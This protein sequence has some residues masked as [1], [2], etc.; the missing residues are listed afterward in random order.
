MDLPLPRPRYRAALNG[1][2]YANGNAGVRWPG[3]AGAAR[4]PAGSSSRSARGTGVERVTTAVAVAPDTARS[5]GSAS[6][7]V[8]SSSIAVAADIRRL[9]VGTSMRVTGAPAPPTVAGPPGGATGHSSAVIEPR[10]SGVGVAS[11]ARRM[12][13]GVSARGATVGVSAGADMQWL[14]IGR[15]DASGAAVDGATPSRAESK[16]ATSTGR[17]AFGARSSWAHGKHA[18]VPVAVAAPDAAAGGASS[19]ALSLSSTLTQSPAPATPQGSPAREGAEARRRDSAA[20]RNSSSVSS[21]SSVGE[22]EPPSPILSSS[23]PS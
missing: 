12:V 15:V 14:E 11:T 13:A 22:I 1:P 17:S 6:S 9:G 2:V 10:N 16:A 18:R 8:T 19:W 20:N 7:G 23:E 21:V 3:S 4:A 5:N